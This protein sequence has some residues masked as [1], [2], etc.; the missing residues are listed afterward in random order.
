MGSD[1]TLANLGLGTRC[2]FDAAKA[3]LLR[4]AD[5]AFLNCNKDLCLDAISKLYDFFDAELKA[6]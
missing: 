6:A 2:D 3:M 1:T 4:D 5:T